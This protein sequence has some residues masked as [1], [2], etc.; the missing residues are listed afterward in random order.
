VNRCDVGDDRVTAYAAE[1]KIPILME[2]PNDRKI[3]EAY[4]RGIMMVDV[5]PEMKDLF[6]NMYE[7]IREL[8]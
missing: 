1:E 3:A 5:V 7:K 2:I 4:S 8:S 6:R